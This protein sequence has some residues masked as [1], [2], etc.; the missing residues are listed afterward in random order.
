VYSEQTVYARVQYS[1]TD[2]IGQKLI[3]C[4]TIYL[5]DSIEKPWIEYRQSKV[6]GS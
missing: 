4:G 3:N 6:G 5:A 1:H 2:V